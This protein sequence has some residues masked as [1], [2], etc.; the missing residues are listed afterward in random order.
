MYAN[1]QWILT[2]ICITALASASVWAS[3]NMAPQTYELSEE[4]AAAIGP[5]VVVALSEPGEERWGWYQ[6]PTLSYM[7]DGAILCAFSHQ[8]DAAF[9]YGNPMAAYVSRDEGRTWEQIESQDSNRNLAAPHG[10]IAKV[11]NGE[12]LLMPAR[13]AFDVT[14][15]HLELPEPV[16]RDFG[17]RSDR[18]YRAEQLPEE[19][20]NYLSSIDAFRWYPES[21]SWVR[22]RVSYSQD[23]AVSWC[24]RGKT[25][26]DWLIPS[27]WFEHPPL[28]SNGELL[29]ADYRQLYMEPDGFV[30]KNRAAS[31][32]VSKD[33]GHSF[34]KRSTIAIDRT[35][36]VLMGEPCLAKTSDGG[37]ACVMRR[38]KGNWKGLMPL[39]IAFSKDNGETWGPP[40][41]FAHLG[42]FPGMVLLE[43]R[44]LALSY[45]R[46]GVHLSFSLDGLGSDWTKPITLREGNPDSLL[47]KSCGYTAIL[48]VSSNAFLV[49]YSNFEYTAQDGT[50]YKAILVRRVTLKRHDGPPS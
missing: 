39:A 17:H 7:P 48:P 45:G 11:Y 30:P 6:F 5:P 20:L 41:S 12:F 25:K 29:Y 44:V 4:W 10:S 34:Y 1:K 26:E 47:T 19:I 40:V 9:A 18:L 14:G 21:K 33:N 43:N 2:V 35:G 42:V 36:T 22:E 13:P 37:L 15:S 3:E 38:Q 23:R 46:P 28:R 27:T 49:A 50:R 8:H 31:L 32:M 16:S 24:T